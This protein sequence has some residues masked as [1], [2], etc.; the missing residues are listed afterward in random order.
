MFSAKTLKLITQ[1]LLLSVVAVVPFLFTKSLYFPYISG[2]V[3][4]FRLLVSLAF[5]FWVW[6]MLKEKA[7]KPNFKNIL[8][9]SLVLFFLAQVLVSFFGVDFR[10]SLFSSIERGDGV[11]QY[12]FWALYFLIILSVFRKEQDWK[13]FFS[14][15]VIVAFLVSLHAWLNFKEQVRLYAIFGNSSYLAVFLLFAIGFGFIILERKFFNSI[16]LKISIILAILFFIITLVATQTRGAYVGLAGGIFLFCLLATLFLRKENKKLAIY[17]GLILF[18]GLISIT[19]LFSARETD[20][21]QNTYI[22]K[23]TTSVANLWEDDVVR[24]RLLTWQIALKASKERPIFGYGPENFASAFNRYYDYRIGKA[25]P[26]FDRAHSQPLDTLATG[27][28]V[29][30]SF[31]LFW[32]A[33]VFYIIFRISRVKKILSFILASTFLAYLL[34]GLFLFDTLPT[35]LGLFPFLGFLVFQS[36]ELRIGT[37]IRISDE[38]RDQKLK[39][40]QN[41]KYKIQNTNYKIL[42]PAGLFSLF[43]IY[44]TCFI[45]YK[46]NALALKFLAYTN[47][48][49]YKGTKQFLEQSFDIKSP[50]TFWEVRKRAGWQFVNVLE[51]NMNDKTSPEDIATL[52]EIY[53]FITPELENFANN[54]PFDPQIYLLL[55]KTY[56]LGFEKLGYND[57]DKAERILK[58]GLNYSDTRIEYFNELAQVLILEGKFE[59]GEDLVRKHVERISSD[60]S[61]SYAILGHFYFAAEKYDLAFE[62]YEK[63]REAGYKFY[64]DSIDFSRYMSTT[65][66]LGEY[67]KIVDIAQAYLER[68]GSD[69]DTF[70]NIAVGY[71]NLGEKEKAKEFFLK[72]VELKEEYEKYRPFF[73]NF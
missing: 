73:E 42:I 29:L 39:E 11:L 17:C 40:K 71:L 52:K 37:N 65:E 67:Q 58:K 36:Y 46:A 13:L 62:Q 51:Y 53:D 5:F 15:F 69:A 44:A 16:L 27:G 64:E 24:E 33:V 35:Y 8:V 61:V 48:G 2:K 54:R 6:L 49:I 7:S 12:G 43:V 56:R 38:S 3:Y 50:Y 22:L 63:A 47:N 45:P 32:L 21:V 66:Q 41:T 1:I 14:V 4:V 55:G 19:A 28:I 59:E 30:F 31:F 57:L 18:L 23:R 70:F 60:D 25:Q 10:Y 20:F 34:Q 72:A 9:I 26:W 68:W